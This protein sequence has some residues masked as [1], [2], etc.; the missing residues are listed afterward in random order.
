MVRVKPQLGLTDYTNLVRPI[1][2]ISFL[3]S[4]S[5]KLGG[6]DMLILVRPKCYERETGSLHCNLGG[7]DR[8]SRWYRNVTKGNIEI[9]IPSW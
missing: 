5:G 1:L 8:S 4:W 9:T 3:E 7:T 6:T 2:V